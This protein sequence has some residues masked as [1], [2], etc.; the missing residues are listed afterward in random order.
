MGIHTAGPFPPEPCSFEVWTAGQNL[1]Q[2]ILP[3]I[4][5]ILAQLIKHEEK[6]CVVRYTNVLIL[7][8]IRKNPHSNGRRLLEEATTFQ[9]VSFIFL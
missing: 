5:Q 9:G 8:G 6:C 4:N 3:G 1:A 7:F 2:Y